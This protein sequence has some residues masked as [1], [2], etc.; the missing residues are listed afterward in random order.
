MYLRL[1]LNYFSL[2]LSTS[3]PYCSGSAARAA[4][5]DA[6]CN[7]PKQPVKLRKLNGGEAVVGDL[8]ARTSQESLV[9][10]VGSYGSIDEYDYGFLSD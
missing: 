6:L 1:K 7:G 10:Q 3:R 8:G 4:Q 9:D 2:R 5:L